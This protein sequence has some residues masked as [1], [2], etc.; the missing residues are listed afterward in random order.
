LRDSS[1]LPLRVLV[2]DDDPASRRF[3]RDGMRSLG[4]SVESC[5]DGTTALDC[6]RVEVFDLLVLDCRM[7]GAGALQILAQLRS[8][9]RAASFDSFAVASSAE[10]EPA[11]QQSLLAA[12]FGDTLRKPC[13]LADL[14][15]MLALVQPGHHGTHLLDDTA[16][17]SAT[18]DKATMHA[19]RSLL[20]EELVQLDHELDQLRLDRAAFGERLHRLRSSCG[21]CGA[22]ALSTQVILLQRQLE[23]SGE[24][25]VSVRRFRHALRVTM[26]ALGN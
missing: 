7:P 21:F 13:A 20:R 14:Q 9:P 17:L 5:A 2:A 16:A 4:A 15:R 24:T 6:V 18:G 12:G 1:S 25:A 10:M 19:L 3:L 11:L 23:S 22:A 8:E 26:Q